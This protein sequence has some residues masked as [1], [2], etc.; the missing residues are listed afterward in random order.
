MNTDDLDVE[1]REAL[2]SIVGAAPSPRPFSDLPRG[3]GQ[4]RGSLLPSAPRGLIA[5][6]AVGLVI[7][8]AGVSTLFHRG[9]VSPMRVAAGGVKAAPILL[10]DDGGTGIYRIDTGGGRTEHVEVPHKNSA[11]AFSTIYRLIDRRDG[12]VFPGDDGGA[13]VANYSLDHVR[14]LGEGNF[15]FPAADDPNIV[16]LITVGATD[17][18]NYAQKVDL[19]SGI[20]IPLTE[21]PKGASIQAAVPEGLLLRW[22][23]PFIVWNPEKGT[24]RELAFP[25]EKER[26]EAIDVLAVQGNVIAW[27]VFRCETDTIHIADVEDGSD[28]ALD[29]GLG[30]FKTASGS[31]SPDGT[32]FAVHSVRSSD[33]PSDFTSVPDQAAVIDLESKKVTD[34]ISPNSDQTIGFPL[35]WS[36][37]GNSVFYT[38]TSKRKPGK[39]G[40]APWLSLREYDLVRQKSSNVPGPDAS[41]VDLV[42][43]PPR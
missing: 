12:V 22:D 3:S 34:E 43:V 39:T 4:R 33:C 30:N 6:L 36:P 38:E 35:A 26:G 8:A 32:M 28:D 42:A 9:S 29:P 31:F 16:W 25:S 15:I 27:T 40:P 11:A 20:L 7:S 5:A 37:S 14:R 13:Y 1:I 19:A 23:G 2:R 10:A 18:P 17:E 41:F 24:Q 21:I